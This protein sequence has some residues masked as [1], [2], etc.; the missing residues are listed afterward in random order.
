MKY[1]YIQLALLFISTLGLIL[2]ACSNK[3]SSNLF[4]QANLAVSQG[5][6]TEAIELCNQ[7]L[8]SKDT[9]TLTAGNYCRL[10][11][12]FAMAADHDI[13]RGE[14]MAEAAKWLEYA[15]K[16]SSDSVNNFYNCLTPEELSVIKQVEI[17]NQ[18]RGI[19][20][21]NITEFEDALTDTTSNNANSNEN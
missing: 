16:L 6:Y 12:I 19:D 4:D 15:N 14:N 18:T 7:L 10:A 9:T 21:S 8:A 20:F 13:N 11:M 2:T 5:K 17:L 3:E 1:L